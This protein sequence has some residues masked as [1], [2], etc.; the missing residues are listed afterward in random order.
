MQT[1]LPYPDFAKSARVLDRQRLGKQRVEA[2]QIYLALT[3]PGY[4]WANHPAVKMWRGCELQLARYGY[5]VCDEWIK[6]GYKDTLQ[7]WFNERTTSAVIDWVFPP[8][9]GNADFHLSH[10]SNLIRKLPSHYGPLWP[11]VPNNLPYIWPV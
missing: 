10:Q 9:L 4:G 1:F 2:K 6:R 11:D 7:D 5:Y 8:W 3:Q